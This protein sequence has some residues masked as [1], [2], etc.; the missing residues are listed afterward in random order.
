[1][2]GLSLISERTHV[3]LSFLSVN[4]QQGCRKKNGPT[5]TLLNPQNDVKRSKQN[6]KNYKKHG[7]TNKRDKS[8]RS[9]LHPNKTVYKTF[10]IRQR[11]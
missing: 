7:K 9:N 4:L 6:I 1:M 3:V 5:L 8:L 11:N 10:K 2:I